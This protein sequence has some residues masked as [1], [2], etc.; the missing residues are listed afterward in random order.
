MISIIITNLLSLMLLMLNI[1]PAL[2][3]T[4]IEE[5]PECIIKT[6]CVLEEWEV[7]DLEKTFSRT[8]RVIE[9]TPRTRIVEQSNTYIHAEAQTKWRHYTD[10]LLIK[11]IPERGVI[12]VRSESRVGIGDNGVNKKRVDELSYRVMT[13]QTE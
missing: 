11:A 10:D 1:N 3:L 6:H 5:L 12:Q 7:A 2:A 8:L 13:N 9:N 4:S